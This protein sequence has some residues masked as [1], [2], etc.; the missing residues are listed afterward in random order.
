MTDIKKIL[1]DRITEIINGWVAEDIYAV[2][3]LIYANEAYSYRKFSNITHFAVSYNTESFCEDADQLSEERW[4][5]AFWEQ[6][7]MPVIDGDEET[8]ET[9]KLF[10]WYKENG[11]T[12]I[13]YEDP[14]CY[15]SSFRYIGK[16]PVG[17]YELLQIAAQIAKELQ[18]EGI[19]KQKFGRRMPIIIHGLE[20]A[21]H[22]IEATKKGNPNGEAD[23]FLQAMEELGMIDPAF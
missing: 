16:G 8:P 9:E 7:E 3:F 18:D 4:N 22:D 19:L 5:Y 1:K 10:A 17:Q 12:N 14:D 2:S 13:G 11:I 15:D 23:V 20:Y 21:W 6:D